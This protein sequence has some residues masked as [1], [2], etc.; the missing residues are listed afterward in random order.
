MLEQAWHNIKLKNV[1]QA[2]TAC[3]QLNQFYPQ[4]A[5][6]WYAT[7]YITL[8]LNDTSQSLMAID[9]ALSIQPKSVF[10]QIHKA[11]ALLS[12]GN[13]KASAELID[14]LANKKYSNAKIY[15]ELAQILSDLQN[16]Q[17]AS[18][19]YEQAITLSPN[20]AQLL[21]NLASV[22]RYLGEIETA[23]EYLS[24]AIKL[25]PWDCE[26]HLLRS[27]LRTQTR[28]NNNIDELTLVY[29]ENTKQPIA[30]AQICYALAKEQ[31]DLGNYQQSF[32][33]LNEGADIRRAHMQYNPENEINTINRII[34]VYDSK[35]VNSKAKGND[36]DE[37]IFVLGL[38]RTGSTLIERIISNHDQVYSAGELNNFALQLIDQCRALK[39]K[40]PESTTDFVQLTTAVDFAK[41]GSSYI[42]STRPDTSNS[43]HFI[44][45]LPLNSLY[46]GL[47]KLALPNAKLIHVQ[48]HPLDTCYSIYKQLFTNGYPF[49][50]NLVELANYYVAHHRLMEHWKA[51]IP[52]TIYSVSYEDLVNNLTTEAQSL[53]QHCKLDWQDKCTEFQSNKAAALTASATQVRQTVYKSSIAKWRNYEQQLS[54]VKKI[55]ERAG[56]S[57]A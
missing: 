31:E 24:K 8:K 12:A 5:E 32:D 26:A 52:N 13:K 2:I 27:T 20:N 30:H 15:I 19:H 50:Y 6:G 3:K 10:W 18:D 21:F 36:N 44:D 14:T 23:E 17:A 37:A 51:V 28:N 39:A 41:L 16:F 9:K 22:K 46:I 38:P 1:E 54:P 55:L 42:D 29:Q 49:S 34:D 25:S 7:S 33:Y 43:K 40:T 48:R 47:I 45:K 4:N 57:C 53:L 11:N 35:M 56:I